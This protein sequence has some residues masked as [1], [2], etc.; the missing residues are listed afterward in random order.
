MNPSVDVGARRDPLG[1]CA[2]RS[3]AHRIL[4]RA[5]LPFILHW[6]KYRF[7]AITNLAGRPSMWMLGKSDAVGKSTDANSWQKACSDKSPGKQGAIRLQSVFGKGG[8]AKYLIPLVACACILGSH[9][10][11]QRVLASASASRWRSVRAM[12][13]L[14]TSAIA[15][16]A[17]LILA[18]VSVLVFRYGSDFASVWGDW[19]EALAALLASIICWQTSRRAGPFGKRVWR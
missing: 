12:S 10:R 16:A 6:F 1:I 13:K 19:I 5:E 2:W 14:R 11:P 4:V 18:H 8:R 17:I 9:F 3:I 7:P 15:A